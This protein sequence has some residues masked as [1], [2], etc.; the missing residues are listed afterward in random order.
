[1]P[2]VLNTVITHICIMRSYAGWY[3][4]RVT[5]RQITRGLTMRGGLPASD[6]IILAYCFF[7]EVFFKLLHQ[8]T[9]VHLPP[10][11]S[12]V[13]G[14]IGNVLFTVL[15]VGLQSGNLDKIKM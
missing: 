15:S 9:Q 3:G 10:L 8:S 6:L 14:L 4:C 7:T 2:C 1:M 13:T 12:R 11:D 5:G